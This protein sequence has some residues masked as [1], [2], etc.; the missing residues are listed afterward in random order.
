MHKTNRIKLIIVCLFAV[1][2]A[3]VLFTNNVI[4]RTAHA[5]SSG[6]PAGY[7]HAPGEE[8]EACA[9]C[10]VNADPGTGRLTIIVPQNYVPGQSY[11]ITVSH[12]NA[13][14]TRIR[15]G[16]EL[17]ALNDSDEKGGTLETLDNLTRL[18][19]GQ[20]P[21]PARQYIEH[22]S[23]GTFLGQ[24]NGASWNF[25][26]TAPPADAGPITFYVAGNEAN[27][28]G[29]SSG[30]NIYSTFATVIPATTPNQID[31]STFFVRQHYNDF[32]NREPDA[33]GLAFWVNQIESCGADAACREARRVN[34]SAAFFLSIEFQ[35]TGYL[36]YRFHQT[37]FNT[38]ET[39]KFNTFLADTQQIGRNVVVGQAGWE[40]QLETNKTAFANAFVAR[41]QF[42]TAYPQT[43]TP[44]QFVD[45]LNLNTRDPQNASPVGALT[46]AER[47]QLVA[48]LTSGAKTRAQVLRAIAENAEFQRR[49]FNKAFVLMQYFGY[50][51]RNPNDTP[52]TDF[53]GYNFWLGK[54]NQFNG[55]YINAEMVKAFLS[56]S[57]YRKRFGT[58]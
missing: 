49:Q 18:R 37:A 30:D 50:L 1:G 58:Q 10:H 26:W 23:T 48:D 31:D 6:P 52:D 8:P 33:S 7:T 47:D 29:N 56:S 22:T 14:Q 20:G 55:N 40:Q 5:F 43:L 32:L 4:N 45:A 11:L 41:A 57:E 25:K 36:V 21:F 15:W 54:L 19:E 38:G 16:F 44:A 13:D 24:H 3:A 27:G 53:G 28:D 51:R 46:Q 9:E 12:A 39:L 35:Q 17:T 2:G 34:V 42:T